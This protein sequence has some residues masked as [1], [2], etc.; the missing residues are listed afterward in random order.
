MAFLILIA[1]FSYSC[2]RSNALKSEISKQE[3]ID[4]SIVSN[5]LYEYIIKYL[6]EGI[7]NGKIGL[8]DIDC[9]TYAF[10]CKVNKDGEIKEALIKYCT[11]PSANDDLFINYLLKMPKFEEWKELNKGCDDS[12]TVVVIPLHF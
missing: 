5:A 7:N 12:L 11:F 10:E 6:C 1:I 3:T 8:H 9:Y 4:D 2:T